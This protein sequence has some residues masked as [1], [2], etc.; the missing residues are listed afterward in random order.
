MEQSAQT[1]F[2]ISTETIASEMGEGLN[3]LG[4]RKEIWFAW[5]SSY[6]TNEKLM[7]DKLY[8]G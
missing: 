2:G 7:L 5:Y 4:D 1:I 3:K 6:D 8:L